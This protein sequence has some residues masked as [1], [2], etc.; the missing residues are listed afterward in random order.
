[1][2]SNKPYN[3]VILGSLGLLMEVS[4]TMLE[5]VSLK[6]YTNHIINAVIG[7]LL[8]IVWIFFLKRAGW[9]RRVFMVIGGIFTT[10]FCLIIL[11]LIYSVVMSMTG[12]NALLT[13]IRSYFIKAWDT[14]KFDFSFNVF[15]F[16]F[17]TFLFCYIVRPKIKEQFKKTASS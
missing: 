13:S 2:E 5:Q 3:I 4:N 14:N 15:Y 16:C 12:N 7:L 6:S 1:M 9:A 11:T 17:Y 10:I 8:I